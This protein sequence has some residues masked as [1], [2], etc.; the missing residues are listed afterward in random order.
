MFVQTGF[1]LPFSLFYKTMSMLQDQNAEADHRPAVCP[2]G[3]GHRHPHE[4]Q[5]AH[6][7]QP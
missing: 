7:H 5:E 4:V 6:P 1:M 2:A 3:P